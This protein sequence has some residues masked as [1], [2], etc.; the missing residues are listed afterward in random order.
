[1]SNS[2]PLTEQERAD[3]VA[4]LDGELTGE[5]ARAME[6]KLSINPEARAEA[7]GL[8]RTWD[9]LDFLPQPEASPNFTNRTLSKLMPVPVETPAQVPTVTPRRWW[10]VAAVALWLV[11]VVLSALGGYAGFQ[12]F[13]PRQPGDRELVRELRL[14]ENKRLYDLVGEMEFLRRLD[15]PDLFGD[16]TSK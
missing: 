16:D 10:K 13:V 12:H 4:Y 6:A 14:I 8:R 5:A 1:M 3:L 9:M 7:E 2:A 11:A 15:Q